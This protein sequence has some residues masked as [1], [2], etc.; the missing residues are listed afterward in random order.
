MRG[1]LSGSAIVSVVVTE[2]DEGVGSPSSSTLRV[3]GR[4]LRSLRHC[5]TTP[6][7]GAPPGQL[8]CG[9]ILPEAPGG[10]ASTAAQSRS[11]T[12]SSQPQGVAAVAHHE[13]G[14]LDSASIFDED[15]LV[16]HLLKRD[17]AH[18][19]LLDAPMHRPAL[20][21]PQGALVPCWHGSK[22]VVETRPN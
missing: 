8:H 9:R 7:P 15:A 17:P 11:L 18:G 19:R 5:C 1:Y 2:L 3:V 22:L 20:R 4:R 21:V 12:A 16:S 10:V 14:Q 6:T 13:G